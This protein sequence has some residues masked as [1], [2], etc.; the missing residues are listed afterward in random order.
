MKKPHAHWHQKPDPKCDPATYTTVNTFGF[1][2][3]TVTRQELLA[4]HK[5]YEPRGSGDYRMGYF[6]CTLIHTIA[7]ARGFVPFTYEEINEYTHLDARTY[8]EGLG[9]LERIKG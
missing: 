4:W 8:L 9:K 3:D 7:K 6:A 2:S 5:I 1:D